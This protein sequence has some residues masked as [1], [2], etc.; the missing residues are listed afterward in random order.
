[1]K[2]LVLSFIFTTFSF[3]ALSNWCNKSYRHENFWIS[4]AG[5]MGEKVQR[6]T[7]LDEMCWRLGQE[8]GQKLKK[9]QAGNL[10]ACDLAFSNG[11][12]D[13]LSGVTQNS[14]F[15]I[16]CYDAG[17]RYGLSVLISNARLGKNV[18]ASSNCVKSYKLG[19]SDGKSDI[20]A[21]PGVNKVEFNCYMGGFQDGALFRDLL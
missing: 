19:L 12:E 20:V 16:A 2:F 18:D 7:F 1:M 9:E 6:N 15:P 14:D 13:G 4:A 5:E 3:N 11:K 10:K 8:Y 21:Q 17:V